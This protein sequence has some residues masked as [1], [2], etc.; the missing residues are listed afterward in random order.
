[1]KAISQL[2]AITLCVMFGL[3]ISIVILFLFFGHMFL[4]IPIIKENEIERHSII[5]ANAFMSSDKLAYYDNLRTYRAVLDKEKLDNEMVNKNNIL[6]YLKIFDES[7]LIKE[8]SYPNSAV[9]LIVSDNEQDSTWFLIGGGPIKGEGTGISTYSQCMLSHVRIDPAMIFRAY[10][11]GFFNPIDAVWTDYDMQACNE[12][13]NANQGFVAFKTFPVAIR[14][15]DNDIHTGV[16][17][18]SLAEV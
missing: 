16:L 9:F 11:K 10:R 3:A 12:V 7:K 2:F 5:L 13:L 17:S 18:L 8:I 1:V 15:S 4:V 14:Y 6:S